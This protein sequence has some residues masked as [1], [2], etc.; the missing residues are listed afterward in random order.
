M[1]CNIDDDTITE[2]QRQGREERILHTRPKDSRRLRMLKCKQSCFIGYCYTN[3][4]FSLTE[5]SPFNPNMA[6]L[7]AGEMDPPSSQTAQ[8]SQ[9]N[10]RLSCKI[11][12][13]R[14]HPPLLSLESSA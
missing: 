8:L 5:F 9:Q 6:D 10:S 14:L 13:T 11:Y 7:A 3:K 1:N 12:R 2:K 4:T